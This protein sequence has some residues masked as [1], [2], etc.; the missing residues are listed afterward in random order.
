MDDIRTAYAAGQEKWDAIVATL[1]LSVDANSKPNQYQ[2][3]LDKQIK[4]MQ[5]LAKAVKDKTAQVKYKDGR[6]PQIDIKDPWT[7]LADNLSKTIVE[8]W[9][10]TGKRLDDARA[11]VTKRLEDSKLPSYSKLPAE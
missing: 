5:T 8:I 7:A 6:A 10:E 11:R 2:A 1:L 4:D 9:K 3:T